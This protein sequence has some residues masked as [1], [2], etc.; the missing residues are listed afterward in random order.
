M[1]RQ[2]ASPSAARSR[3]SPMARPW[4]LALAAAAA[5]LALSAAALSSS[6]HFEKLGQP[7]VADVGGWSNLQAMR[8]KGQKG[9]V[10]DLRS[11]SRLLLASGSS[12]TASGL[13]GRSNPSWTHGSS[14]G[15]RSGDQ[16]QRSRLSRGEREGQ[17]AARE[18]TTLASSSRTDR[19][20]RWPSSLAGRFDQ[21]SSSSSN[22]HARQ[23]YHRRAQDQ[24][25]AR[26]SDSDGILSQALV[27]KQFK[28]SSSKASSKSQVASEV[29]ANSGGRS[30]E[31]STRG[32]D[33]HAKV[34]GGSEQPFPRDDLSSDAGWSNPARFGLRRRSSS[35]SMG[36]LRVTGRSI[37]G[38]RGGTAGTS[39]MDSRGDRHGY[40]R[41]GDYLSLRDV[42]AQPSQVPEDNPWRIHQDLKKGQKQMISQAW[43][44]HCR[45]RQHVSKSPKEVLQVM[46]QEW[47]S[48]MQ[49]CLNE[50]FV[51]KIDITPEM[52]ETLEYKEVLDTET[53]TA[54]KATQPL[55]GEIYTATEQIS[56]QAQLRG[57]RTSA[58]MS[59]ENGWDFRKAEHRKACIKKVLEEDPFCLILAFP[60]GP[61]SPL[62]RLRASSTLEERRKE[63]EV[64]L[65]FALILAKIQIRRGGHFVIENPKGSMAWNLPQ[66]MRFLEETGCAVVDF[67]Q[68]RFRLKSL[69]GFLHKKPTRIVT[70]SAAVAD[71]LRDCLCM[72]TIPTIQ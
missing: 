9:Q 16:D 60:C 42:R 32:A 43:E 31:S 11:T 29:L 57:H 2:M 61:W 21:V 20:S 67:D 36:R 19:S 7:A 10:D 4:N 54:Y 28:S 49:S 47:N 35:E 45:D 55:V 68:R 13:H 27:Q 14:W 23:K 51:M 44:Q 63:G 56:K 72:V 71:G 24:D 41:G 17:A 3:K 52:P 1:R 26:R 5:F 8:A 39:W 58:S 18:G 15:E 40:G 46:H 53:A 34:V 62:T 66:M 22:Q 48:S 25:Q 38:E 50:P 12:W 69:R 30:A 33:R 65:D 64:L 37:L 70:S 6:G 59:L